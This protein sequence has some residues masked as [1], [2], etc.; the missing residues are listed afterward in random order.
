MCAYIHFLSKKTK[1]NHTPDITS[2]LVNLFQF[3][4]HRDVLAATSVLC[5]IIGV[6][7]ECQIIA[8]LLLVLHTS[9]WNDWNKIKCRAFYVYKVTVLNKCVCT[10]SVK[11]ENVNHSLQLIEWLAC[12]A[13]GRCLTM[14]WNHT[15]SLQRQLK[16]YKWLMTKGLRWFHTIMPEWCSPSHSDG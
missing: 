1:K 14:L 5:P 11:N 6:G 12:T 13:S 2:Q 7:S 15:G 4:P 10:W 8:T 9:N 16:L 3:I